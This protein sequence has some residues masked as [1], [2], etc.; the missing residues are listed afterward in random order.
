MHTV[1]VVDDDDFMRDFARMAIA[2]SG[3]PI[4]VVEASDGSS[5]LRLLKQ[6]DFDADLILLDVNMPRMNG[7]EFLD[8]YVHETE[9]TTPVVMLSGSDD[10]ADRSRAMSHSCVKEYFVKPLTLDDIN[11]LSSLIAQ[12]LPN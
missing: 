6:S 7:Y 8:A 3:L 1:L 5:A 11:A 12:L 10:P 4:D 2:R 9:S